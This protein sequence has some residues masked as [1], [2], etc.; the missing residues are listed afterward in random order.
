MLKISAKTGLNCENLVDEIIRRVPPP[1]G[2]P[3]KPTRAFLFN[4]DYIGDRGVKCM[5]Q[6]IDGE[7]DISNNRSIY[8]YHKNRKY[9]MF[10]VGVVTPHLVPTGVL[11]TGQVG[12]FLS[13]MKS[14]QDAHI[15][16]TFY[17]LGDGSKITPFPGYIP[18]QCMVFAGLYPENASSYE[19]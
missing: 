19:N 14:I 17:N 10:E 18:P 11:K 16:D 12:Y 5:V 6:I 3:N 8:S 15:G 7:L 9:D 13:N 4:A 1:S 2:D